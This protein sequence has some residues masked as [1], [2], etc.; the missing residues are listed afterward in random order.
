MSDSNLDFESPGFE[1]L[2]LYQNMSNLYYKLIALNY[3]KEFCPAYRCPPIHKHYFSLPSDNVSE[4]RFLYSCL[5]AWLIKDKCQMNLELEPEEYQDPDL[6]IEV[7]LEAIRLLLT[8]NDGDNSK[9]KGDII[10]FPFGKLRSGYGPEVIWTMNILADRALELILA[11]H[12]DDSPTIKPKM[13][14]HNKSST[15]QAI[16]SNSNLGGNNFIVIGQPFVGGGLTTRPLG[17]YQI[18][19]KS[20]LLDD[21]DK[22]TQDKLERKRIIEQTTTNIDAEDWYQQVQKVSNILGTNSS[23]IQEENRDSLVWHQFYDSFNQ[24]KIDIQDF[25]NQ[26]KPLLDV[27][28]DRIDRQMQIINGREKFIQTNL[29]DSIECFSEILRDYTIH[30]KEHDDLIEQV[31]RKTNTFENYNENI[32]KLNNQIESRINELNDASKLDELETKID[33]LKKEN[34]SFDL[35]IGLLL[36]MYLERQ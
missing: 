26:S 20:L 2:R 12:E 33:L 35:K 30:L 22:D 11:N 16:R 15:D 8:E 27:I 13:H 17:S 23:M 18:D 5:C 1:Y 19:D 32:K 34:L 9:N 14:F 10:R 4:Q 3:Q 31:T 6:I 21:D 29:K 24:S 25:L 7:I 36:P 28:K